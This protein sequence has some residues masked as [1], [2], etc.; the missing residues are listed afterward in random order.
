MKTKAAVAMT[1]IAHVG[2]ATI[3]TGTATTTPTVVARAFSRMRSRFP[4]RMYRVRM[5][6]GSGTQYGSVHPNATP[7]AAVPHSAMPITAATA[8]AAGTDSR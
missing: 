6:I 1:E 4:I 3:A 7:I 8:T 5:R 2:R